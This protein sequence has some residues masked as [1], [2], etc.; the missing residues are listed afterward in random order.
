[1]NF[2]FK[3]FEICPAIRLGQSGVETV[4]NEYAVEYI[5]DKSKFV[6]AF[7]EY[8]NSESYWDFKSVGTK[9][10][11]YREAGL[12][13]F[14]LSVINLLNVVNDNTISEED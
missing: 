5:G 7:I 14:I 12:E 11:E 9:Y 2:K 8:D 13:K 4:P 6:I 3:N 1:M 10:L